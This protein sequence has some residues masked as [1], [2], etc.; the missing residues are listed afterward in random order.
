M[1]G[2]AMCRMGDTSLKTGGRISDLCDNLEYISEYETAA[3]DERTKTTH[4]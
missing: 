1:I 4:I 3:G 2:G